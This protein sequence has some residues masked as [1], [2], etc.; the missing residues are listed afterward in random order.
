[1]KALPNDMIA[2]LMANTKT[3]GVYGQKLVEFCDSDEPAINPRES[4]PIEFGTKN[5]NS[6]YQS[7]NTNIKKAKLEDVLQAKMYDGEC[8]LIHKERIIVHL[9]K[10]AEEQEQEVA[11]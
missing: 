7:L 11:A 1:M 10:A 2:E 4:W 8:F 6:V 9:T 3:K 5:A